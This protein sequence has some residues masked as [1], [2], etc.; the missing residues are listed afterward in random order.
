MGKL[1]KSR[2]V[3]LADVKIDPYVNIDAGTMN[4]FEHGE[5]FVLDD[6]G[7]VDQD[8]GNYARFLDLPMGRWNNITTGKA[9]NSVI[10]RER[11]CDSLG[12]PVQLSPPLTTV[13]Q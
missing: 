1:L 12:K 5:V 3:K 4:P 9:Y 6:G 10:D 7:E 11:R 8:L 2:G 13:T